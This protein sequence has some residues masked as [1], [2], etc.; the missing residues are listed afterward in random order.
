MM[1]SFTVVA[2]DA[3]MSSALRTLT[4]NGRSAA[5]SAKRVAVTVIGGRLVC[6]NAPQQ[7]APSAHMAKRGAAERA[8]ALRG[9]SC[10]EENWDMGGT[11]SNVVVHS[12]FPAG[13][14]LLARRSHDTP[15]V[16]RYPGW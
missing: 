2:P 1:A 12:R 6:A 4:P 3:L 11:H 14:H 9:A 15:P 10:T 7:A 5:A 16:G 8:R 13:P